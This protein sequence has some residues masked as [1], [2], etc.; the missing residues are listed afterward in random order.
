MILT[1]AKYR[2]AITDGC[3]AAATAALVGGAALDEE[4]MARA[5][6]RDAAL[7]A[8]E[9]NIMVFRLFFVQDLEDC[10]R[11]WYGM[12]VGKHNHSTSSSSGGA[13]VAEKALN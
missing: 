1:L 13:E 2:M 7:R 10:P 12:F 8:E 4:A 3:R 11:G 5:A 9:E 6:R